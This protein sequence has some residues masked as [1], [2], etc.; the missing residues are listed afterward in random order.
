M[1]DDEHTL[2]DVFVLDVWH[3]DGGFCHG[4]GA[5]GSRRV[6]VEV[7]GLRSWYR[8]IGDYV[9]QTEIHRRDV[10][11]G[12]IIRGACVFKV[13]AQRLGGSARHEAS[14]EQDR[15]AALGFAL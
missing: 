9:V 8:L 5:L 13:V 2:N 14:I 15:H 10:A 12:G 4:V 6:I 3:R 11:T 7:R 1:P